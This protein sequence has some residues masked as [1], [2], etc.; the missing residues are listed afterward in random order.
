MK[1]TQQLCEAFFMLL[2][3]QN[4]KCCR[5][6]VATGG[7]GPAASPMAM[8]ETND[9]GSDCYSASIHEIRNLFSKLL[10]IEK[11]NKSFKI[12]NSKEKTVFS[13]HWTIN[14]TKQALNIPSFSG[15][16][17]SVS[18]EELMLS[19]ITMQLVGCQLSTL[20]PS[21]SVDAISLISVSLVSIINFCTIYWDLYGLFIQSFLISCLG[22]L[23]L[24]SE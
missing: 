6:V 8:D 3:F 4:D 20:I 7:W 2:L 10:F 24:G 23:F 19:N 14:D 22:T 11:V 16:F 1:N 15:S 13:K 21:A 5:S 17:N 12:I 18:L 9:H